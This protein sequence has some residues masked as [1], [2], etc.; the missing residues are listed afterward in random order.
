MYGKG[1][2]RVGE[3]LDMAIEKD[4]VAK[5]E[6]GLVLEILDWDRVKRM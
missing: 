2:S 1:I 5:S 3:I 6:L 4:I